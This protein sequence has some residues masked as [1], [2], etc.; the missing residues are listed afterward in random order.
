M[1]TGEKPDEKHIEESLQSTIKI[2]YRCF[3][4]EISVFQRRNI[5]V[6]EEKYRCFRGENGC[7]CL[8]VKGAP[9]L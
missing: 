7:K 1:E 3:R 2:D 8:R 6:S 9:A 5:G 4:G